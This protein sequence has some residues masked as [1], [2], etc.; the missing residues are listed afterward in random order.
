MEVLCIAMDD[1]GESGNL[2]ECRFCERRF[3][4]NAITR[5][6][7]ICQKSQQKKRKVFDSAKQRVEGTEITTVKKRGPQGQ[8][9]KNAKASGDEPEAVSSSSCVLL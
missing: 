7:P 2:V 4:A 3:N 6:E 5:H 9:N 1:R 8:Q